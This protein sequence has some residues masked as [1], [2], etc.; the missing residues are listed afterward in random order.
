M[1]DQSRIELCCC[2]LFC[3]ETFEVRCSQ[4][5]LEILNRLS[6]QNRVVWEEAVV[7]FLSKE[8][9]LR[10]EIAKKSAL[11]SFF[12]LV[13]EKF[14]GAF[15][16]R[17]KTIIREIYDDFPISYFVPCSLQALHQGFDL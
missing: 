1:Q 13:E 14:G 8:L 4:I 12:N 9:F 17:I 10:K 15:V 16:F 7:D 6:S 11:F 5:L 2:A 3:N